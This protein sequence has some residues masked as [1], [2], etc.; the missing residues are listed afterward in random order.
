MGER[1]QG[2]KPEFFAALGQFVYEY[3]EIEHT[4]FHV[5]RV[6][7]RLSKNTSYA[8]FSGARV[9]ELVDHI[10]RF[11][12]AEG[13]PLSSWLERAFGK[14]GEINTV[15]NK[16]LHHGI[17]VNRGTNYVTD[18]FRNSPLRAKE[19]SVTIED[20]QN[21]TEDAH[22]V[23]ACLIAHWVRE[24]HI[25]TFAQ[26]QDWDAIALRPWFYKFP[27]LVPPEGVRRKRDAA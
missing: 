14:I 16:L 17:W 10:K 20:L 9:S 4:M 21:I 24:R 6:S 18:R 13:K 3:A 2:L 26:Y 8:L 23:R 15:R 7:L 25:K 22:T 12:A 11:Y 27:Q 1:F 5:L 19:F